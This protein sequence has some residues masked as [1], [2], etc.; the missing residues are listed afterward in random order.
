MLT[1]RWLLLGPKN[2]KSAGK[3]LASLEKACFGF[4]LKGRP[5]IT[6]CK[7]EPPPPKSDKTICWCS[8]IFR[9]TGLV[10]LLRE[11]KKRRQPSF[12][13]PPIRHKL[14]QK[15]CPRRD[16]RNKRTMDRR[17]W[18]NR[19]LTFLLTLLGNAKR[20]QCPNQVHGKTRDRSAPCL[21]FHRELHFKLNQKVTL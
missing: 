13:L 14:T 3:P 10:G 11:A 15:C 4:A 5:R 21:L 1:P 6:R 20:F 8:I 2:L 17:L 12:E 9:G 18:L 19:P 16:F 7:N